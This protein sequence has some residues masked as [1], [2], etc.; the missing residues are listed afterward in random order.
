MAETIDSPRRIVLDM[1]STE[2]PVY[3]QRYKVFLHRA[4][5]WMTARRIA[6]L[7][8]P[9]GL[10]AGAKQAGRRR[11]GTERYLRGRLK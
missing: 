3:G 8:V 1:D 6:A 11:Q 2:I 4:A 10:A 7:H 5:D 9:G